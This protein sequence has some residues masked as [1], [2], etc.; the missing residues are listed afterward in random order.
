MLHH[1][2]TPL[3][4]LVLLAAMRA[5]FE[6]QVRLPEVAR[7]EFAV[8]VSCQLFRNMTAK[9]QSCLSAARLESCA[10]GSAGTPPFPMNN[11]E[12]RPSAHRKDRRST[13]GERQFETSREDRPQPA[14]RSWPSGRARNRPRGIP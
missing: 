8:D 1:L 5:L 4:L 3:D 10:H 13:A 11:R 2:H 6:V 9:H 14:V 12:L 7:R